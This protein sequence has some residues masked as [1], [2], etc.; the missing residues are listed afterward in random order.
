[1]MDRDSN[2]RDNDALQ[3]GETNPAL[4]QDERDFGAGRQRTVDTID[5]DD[6]KHRDVDRDPTL[7][8][9]HKPSGQTKE[10]AQ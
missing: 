9:G 2:R 10:K 1:M 4:G 6:A 5:R 3:S 7:P 8:A